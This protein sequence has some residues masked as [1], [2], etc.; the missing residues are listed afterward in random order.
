MGKIENI[1]TSL[2]RGG[3]IT[4]N[5]KVEIVMEKIEEQIQWYKQCA[6]NY[7][8]EVVMIELDKINKL[9]NKYH[10]N[11]EISLFIVEILKSFCNIM[12]IQKEQIAE[13]SE[14]DV[15][16]VDINKMIELFFKIIKTQRELIGYLA[17]ESVHEIEDGD[18]CDAIDNCHTADFLI[19][20]FMP[21][22]FI[23]QSRDSD[24]LKNSFKDDK[25]LQAAF[26]DYC[27]SNGKSSYTAN[28]YCSRIRN[29]WKNYYK[30]Y[31]ESELGDE[32]KPCDEMISPENP[33]LNVYNH[34]DVIYR[35]LIMKLNENE[36]NRNLLNARAAFNKFDDFKKSI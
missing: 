12:D 15:V 3:I 10:E 5:K 20:R 19:N 16:D 24:I 18:N 35:Y 14:S 36:D 22:R 7:N 17:K 27:L 26:I 4:K 31:K 30:E 11:A 6:S 34:S 28:D 33:L 23:S 2:G 25:Q 1:L 9:Y 8:D 13:F 29:L 32:L 21:C